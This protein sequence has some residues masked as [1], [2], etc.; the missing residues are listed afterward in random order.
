MKQLLIMLLFT[1]MLCNSA[2]K[3]TKVDSRFNVPVD[4]PRKRSKS[5]VGRLLF[6]QQSSPRSK[7]IITIW[8]NKTTDPVPGISATLCK[9]VRSKSVPQ[10]DIESPE[11]SSSPVQE[12]NA[13]PVQ[14]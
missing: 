7:D 1:V 8:N 12:Q 4:S 9:I 10:V 13:A 6:E 3:P 14:S 2:D 11:D 5:L